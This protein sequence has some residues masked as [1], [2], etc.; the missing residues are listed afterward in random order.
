[1]HHR[2]HYTSQD[3]INWTKTSPSTNFSGLTG[4]ITRTQ[5]GYFAFWPASSQEGILT[6]KASD[7][8][9]LNNWVPRPEVSIPA[10]EY[11]G[12]NFRDPVRGF[13]YQGKWYVG[14]GCNNMSNSAD[15]CLFEASDATLSKFTDVGPLFSVNHTYGVRDS[16]LV[17]HNNSVKATMMEC[18]DILPLGSDGRVMVIASLFS[19]NQWW[20][21]KIQGQPPRFVPEN[22]GLLDFGSFYAGKTGSRSPPFGSRHLLFAF[23]G[24]HNPTAKPECGRSILL[25]RDVSMLDGTAV[26]LFD[27]IPELENLRR[28][29]QSWSTS[30]TNL[31]VGSGAQLELYFG[32]GIN[33]SSTP[34]ERVA[35]RVLAS[36]GHYTEIGYDFVQGELYAD[37]SYCCEKANNVRQVAPLPLS[38]LSKS[39]SGEV[40]L[41]ATVFVDGGLIESFAGRQVVLTTM[42]NPAGSQANV[43][44]SFYNPGQLPCA[45]SSWKMA[46]VRKAQPP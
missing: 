18:P 24:W 25:P 22:V 20:T 36:E 42:V 1:M 8:P 21:G 31:T 14:V 10:P 38:S 7:A 32:C 37:H 44:A 30:Q 29:G 26:P 45:V 16:N 3:L 6:A 43:T 40:Q 11:T 19:T 28:D 39:P 34:T 2:S 33:T 5:E 46:Q 41:H 9:T 35:F 27:P 23:S 12:K 15:F 13:E 4:S 17:W